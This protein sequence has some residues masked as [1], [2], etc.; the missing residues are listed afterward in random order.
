MKRVCL[1]E[2]TSADPVDQA[3]IG[4]RGLLSG[5]ISC[6]LGGMGCICRCLST[7]LPVAGGSD[8]EI[9]GLFI[10]VGPREERE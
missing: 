6:F 2:A 7:E 8:I 10:F 3:A 5:S 4:H 9:P 1:S